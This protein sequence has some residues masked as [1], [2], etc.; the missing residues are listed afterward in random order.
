MT[1]KDTFQGRLEALMVCSFL[2]SSEKWPLFVQKTDVKSRA[3][4]ACG[5]GVIRQAP[6]QSGASRGLGGLYSVL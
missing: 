6:L 3:V 4:F 5:Q 2:Q 1:K